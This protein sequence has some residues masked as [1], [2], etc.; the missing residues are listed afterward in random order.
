[1]GVNKNY[2][3]IFQSIIALIVIFLSISLLQETLS[4]SDPE[5]YQGTYNGQFIMII[6]SFI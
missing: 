4:N 3:T 6:Y 5:P 1:M 2:R